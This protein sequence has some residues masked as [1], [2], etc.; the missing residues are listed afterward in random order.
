MDEH[1]LLASHQLEQGYSSQSTLPASSLASSSAT[2]HSVR[3]AV[4]TPRSGITVFDVRT[5]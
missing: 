5:L 2:K 3:L 1:F 4:S